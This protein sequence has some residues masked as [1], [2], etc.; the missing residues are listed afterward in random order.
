MDQGRSPSLHQAPTH[1]ARSNQQW[2]PQSQS[3]MQTTQ[4]SIIQNKTCL[5]KWRV[6]GEG[7]RSA[8]KWATSPSSQ[9]GMPQ[10]TWKGWFCKTS[11]LLE[12]GLVGPQKGKHK[13]TT[14]PSNS[15]PRYRPQEQSSGVQTKTWHPCEQLDH[16]CQK[17]ETAHMSID[18]WM[19]K[20]TRSIYTKEYYS[21]IKMD[22]ALR[23]TMT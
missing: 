19:D 17:V 16:N 1:W 12:G 3:C 22:E 7:R 4:T 8:H 2:A 20:Q 18:R 5:I 14:W 10:R 15:T 9:A 6:S 11:W 23:H 21:A 13:I